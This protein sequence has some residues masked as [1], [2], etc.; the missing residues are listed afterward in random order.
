MDINQYSFTHRDWLRQRIN[1][2]INL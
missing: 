2:Q 1:N